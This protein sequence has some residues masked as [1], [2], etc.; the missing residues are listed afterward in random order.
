[1]PLFVVLQRKR[2]RGGCRRRGVRGWRRRAID[3]PALCVCGGCHK[4]RSVSPT[5]P[6]FDLSLPFLDLSLPFLDL[7]LPFNAFCLRSLWSHCADTT[8]GV[9][10]AAGVTGSAIREEMAERL[11]AAMVPA[12]IEMIEQLPL[13]PGGKVDS[14]ALRRLATPAAS[15]VR[16]TQPP[17]RRLEGVEPEF[18]AVLATVLG[19]D[20]DSIGV[21]D[22]LAEVLGV[23]SLRIMELT[24][25]LAADIDWGKSAPLLSVADVQHNPTVQR[26]AQLHSARLAPPTKR[27]RPGVSPRP[28]VRL[29]GIPPPLRSIG[30]SVLCR[31]LCVSVAA[32]SFGSGA[33]VSRPS[34]HTSTTPPPASRWRTSRRRLRRLRRRLRL[35]RRA[36]TA[37]QC[38]RSAGATPSSASHRRALATT[39]CSFDTRAN[40]RTLYA[41]RAGNLHVQ[42]S[43]W[44]PRKYA[45]SVSCVK[46]REHT[47]NRRSPLRVP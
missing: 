20:A 29:G 43:M 2:L 47:H 35:R 42:S 8:W 12:T 14:E 46:S 11:P 36:P 26:L 45:G 28:S 33:A 10:W 38:G 21:D 32:D 15:T 25:R 31:V 24:N 16:P 22:D 18:V 37:R 5:L 30:R 3:K 40:I 19:V 17:R 41:A 6:F 27:H 13:K 7:S 1:M 23:D 4:A 44:C 39:W 34:R 9:D